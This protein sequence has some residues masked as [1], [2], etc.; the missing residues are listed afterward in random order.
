MHHIFIY[1]ILIAEFYPIS[2][3]QGRKK[4]ALSKGRCCFVVLFLT[5]H[6]TVITLMPQSFVADEFMS[7]VAGS[8]RYR[9]FTA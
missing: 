5:T 3:L 9:H 4:K 1:F 7:T 8:G 2:S 6:Y